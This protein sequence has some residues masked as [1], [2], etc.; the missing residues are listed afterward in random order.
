VSLLIPSKPVYLHGPSHHLPEKVMTNEDVLKWIGKEVRAS[1][2]EHRT[3]IQSRHWVSDE[4]ACSDLGYAAA[5]K[6][7]AQCKIDLSEIRQIVL[8]T[9]SG[10]YLTPPSSPLIAHRLGLQNTGAVDL[11]AA[12]AGFVSGVH[13]AAAMALATNQNQLLVNSE[14]R[15][16]FLSKTQFNS[17]VL[18]GDGAS[19][20]MVSTESSNAH[21][22][23]M[24]S[25]LSSD[26]SVADLISIPAG[27]S[28]KPFQS[29]KDPTGEDQE[30]LMLTMKDGAAIFMKAVHGMQ[31]S[32]EQLLKSL[33]VSLEE[34]DWIVPHQANGMILKELEKRIPHAQGKV[35]EVISQTGNTSGA[36]VGIA[37]S[38][39]LHSKP[40]GTLKKNAKVLLVSAGGGGLA[41]SAL[42]EVCV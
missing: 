19:A 33:N 4:E 23:L 8:G 38:H 5:K 6:L 18:F 40:A 3:G 35:I 25:L 17:A 13:F 32:A 29:L 16:K 37:L 12:C 15:S 9:V 20:C 7:E 2:I 41:A 10:D 24:G 1:W 31:E 21:F 36:S 39:L 34:I 27:G 28:R 14:V 42:L 22:R 30:F 11:G 26:G